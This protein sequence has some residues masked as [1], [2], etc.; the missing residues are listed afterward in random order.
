[1]IS[2]EA[3]YDQKCFLLAGSLL[4]ELHVSMALATWADV[5]EGSGAHG[6]DCQRHL[7]VSRYRGRWS[8]LH[9]KLPEDVSH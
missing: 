6:C 4:Q 2:D 5:M 8:A 7:K 3:W 1:M 9:P